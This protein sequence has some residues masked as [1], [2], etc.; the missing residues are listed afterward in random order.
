MPPSG[1]LE[2]LECKEKVRITKGALFCWLPS[3]QPQH[4]LAK[5]ALE[6]VEGCSQSSLSQLSHATVLD[7][8]S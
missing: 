2:K 5:V 7:C 1:I 4:S 8:L 3:Q 6:D